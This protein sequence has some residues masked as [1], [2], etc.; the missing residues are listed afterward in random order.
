MWRLGE[1][2]RLGEKLRGKEWQSLGHLRHPA[3]RSSL[4]AAALAGALLVLA[5]FF[6]APRAVAQEEET[7]PGDDVNTEYSLRQIWTGAEFQTRLDGTSAEQ[8]AAVQ[9]LA[10]FPSQVAVSRL[11]PFLMRPFALVGAP[12]MA[13]IRAL[14][15]HAGAT[16]VQLFLFRTLT[17]ANASTPAQQQPRS[18]AALALA[19]AGPSSNRWLAHAL[20]FGGL[21]AEFAAAA[22]SAHPSPERAALLSGWNKLASRNQT[23]TRPAEPAS[24]T[25]KPAAGAGCL[26]RESYLLT[27]RNE[28]KTAG[29]AHLFNAKD[30][31][32]RA[33]AYLGLTFHPSLSRSGALVN[34]YYQEASAS[35]RLRILLALTRHPDS[36]VL[37]R[38]FQDAA[39]L[40]PSL[41]V[42][43]AARSFLTLGNSD[44]KPPAA[45]GELLTAATACAP[46]P[47][48][49]GLSPQIQERI[50]SRH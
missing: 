20:S 39:D 16:Q 5:S 30:E 25:P 22:L 18:M 49:Q 34:G 43:T 50:E 27:S 8:L 36:P 35:V 32:V 1:K 28:E 6:M 38:L 24:A 4:G 21:S 26:A 31:A 11:H 41:A 19:A 33:A 2:P 9:Y 40:D 45:L 47:V 12:G 14:A 7:A 3:S 44:R 10:H 42:R 17:A 15:P 48:G 13:A 29:L 46:D 37:L 23:A